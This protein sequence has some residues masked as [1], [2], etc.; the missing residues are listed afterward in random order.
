MPINKLYLANGLTVT[1]AGAQAGVAVGTITGDYTVKLWITAL[2]AFARIAIEEAT[3]N[4]FSPAE[5]LAVWNFSPGFN[6]PEGVMVSFR[7][8]EGA[9]TDI[10][11]EAGTFVRVNV[12]ELNAYLPSATFTC[13][14][15]Y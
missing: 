4:A 3:S 13:W 15:E 14:I 12:Q 8:R 10:V 9:G 2:S 11:G 5:Q 6:N 7:K 1:S